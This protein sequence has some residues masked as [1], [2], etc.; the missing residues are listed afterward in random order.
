M[1]KP[2]LCQRGVVL[3]AIVG[4]PFAVCLLQNVEPAFSSR[5]E[6][7][8]PAAENLRTSP[9]W[10]DPFTKM[11]FVFIP[12]GSFQMGSPASEGGREE[13]EVQHNVR[14]TRGFYLGKF[15]VTQEEWGEVMGTNPSHFK[16][17]GGRCPV[18]NVNWYDVDRFIQRLEELSP[19]D[20]FRLPTEAEWEYACRA[21]TTTPFSTGENLSAAQANYDG[22]FPYLQF[23]KGEFRK[24]P[25]AV[26]SFAPNPWG[27]Y[28]MH[29]NVWEWCED[30]YCPCTKSA[31]TDPLGS[32]QS[33][34]KVIRGGSWYFDA[35]SARSAL[36]YH[37]RPQDLGFSI[38]F[39]LVRES[40]RERAQEIQDSDSVSLGTR[41]VMVPVTVRDAAGAL[42]R[43]LRKE[44]FEISEGRRRR[45]VEGFASKD[46][47]ASVVL[48]L[49]AS[50]SV[51]ERLP[52]IREAALGFVQALQPGDSVA[53][54]QFGD[55]VDVIQ[56]WTLDRGKIASALRERFHPGQ[57]TALYD[58]IYEA[59]ARLLAKKQ[60]RKV[61][62]LLTDGED[63]GSLLDA[64]YA[65]RSIQLA[66]ALLYVISEA[67]MQVD[68]MRRNVAGA[69][70][71]LALIAAK[72]ES[73][74]AE[75]AKRAAITG[76]RLFSPAEKSELRNSYLEIAEELRNQYILTFEPARGRSRPSYRKIRVSLSKPG[77]QIYARD[78]YYLPGN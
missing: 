42:V 53:V 66:N 13:G 4:I 77:F 39:R 9:E 22:E 29:G 41:E 57:K 33:E 1:T 36:R 11:P 37:H 78:G 8:T 47:P 35:N 32:C 63:T 20:K 52:E 59:A 58:G 3:L 2:S 31:A 25:T 55:K 56:N 72:S 44:D 14:L 54:A 51:F 75:L 16:D 30:A 34:L 26:G 28:D 67:R 40:P 12:A 17:C 7:Q 60:G 49:D 68:Q 64:R 27:L 23:P 70:V 65:F 6:R 19:G 48:L 74:E 61:I 18:E 50:A 76:G 21:G 46:V 5:A 43:G 69:R 62:V 45:K 10:I 71:R 38:G 24:G 73:T 15:E